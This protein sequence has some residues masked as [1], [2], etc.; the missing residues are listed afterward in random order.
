MSSA[1]EN[2][3]VR[4]EDLAAD[5]RPSLFM[6][7]QPVCSHDNLRAQMWKVQGRGDRIRARAMESNRC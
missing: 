2:Y 5:I 3:S 4:P 1:T 7:S 6:M